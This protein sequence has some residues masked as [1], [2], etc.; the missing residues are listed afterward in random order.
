MRRRRAGLIG[1]LALLSAASL[2]LWASVLWW[3]PAGVTLAVPIWRSHELDVTLWR[4]GRGYLSMDLD[5]GALIDFA[6]PIR[7][8]VWYQDRSAATMQALGAVAL[9]TWPLLA[10]AAVLASLAGALWRRPVGPPPD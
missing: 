1:G 9:P 4:P 6:G 8:A 3:R 5:H 2:G 7:L 10:M